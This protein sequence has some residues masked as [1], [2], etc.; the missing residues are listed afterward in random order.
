MNNST[1]VKEKYFRLEINS[2]AS[3][4]LNEE[5]QFWV[6]WQQLL[7]INFVFRVYVTLSL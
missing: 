2:L 6:K 5:V 1:F 7:K 3:E 4:N